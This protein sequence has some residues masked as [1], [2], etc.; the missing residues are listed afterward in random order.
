MLRGLCLIICFVFSAEISLKAQIEKEFKIEERKGFNIVHVDFNVYKGITKLH[1][2]HGDSPLHINSHLSKVNILPTFSHSIKNGVLSAHLLHRNVESE[3][4]GK[5][6]SYKLFSSD[7]EDYDHKWNIGLSAN[8]LYD[9]NLYFGIGKADLDFS[10]LPISNC[11]IKSASADIKLNYAK[12]F[13]NSVTMDTLK[14]SINMGNLEVSNINYANAEN[15]IFEINYGTLDLSF[16][17]NLLH[18]AKVSAVV[19]AGKVNLTLPDQSQPYK[20]KIKSTPM[21]RTYLPKYLKDIGDKTYV[22]K[23]YKADAPDLLELT[24]DVSVGS[25][26]VK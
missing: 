3:T 13:S 22:S 7:S 26:T 10:N 9:L 8:H 21:C 25:V 17:D 4:L 19:G 14:V 18:D 12:K 23:S 5:S 15:M 16:S 24:I 2:E 11:N 20:L 1:R 6:L